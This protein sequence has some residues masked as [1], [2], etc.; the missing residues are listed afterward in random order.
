MARFP[1]TRYGSR[2]HHLPYRYRPIMHATFNTDNVIKLVK[3]Q[4]TFNNIDDTAE[5]NYSVLSQICIQSMCTPSS[6]STPLFHPIYPLYATLCLYE[7]RSSKRTFWISKLAPYNDIV[8]YLSTDAVSLLAR[9]AEI[10]NETTSNMCPS[11]YSSVSFSVLFFIIIM[12][13]PLWK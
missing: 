8:S 1:F 10:N 13:Q 12:R 2:Q 5:S 7:K 4:I 9:A 6:T 11:N 3:L